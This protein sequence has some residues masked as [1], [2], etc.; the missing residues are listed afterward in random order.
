ML[1]VVLDGGGPFVDV[2]VFDDGE[3]DA[4]SELR[5]DADVDPQVGEEVVVVIAVRRRGGGVGGW[6]SLLIQSH[7]LVQ[8]L[9]NAG[10]GFLGLGGEGR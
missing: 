5:R 2:D 1:V 7:G 10:S 3:E 9:L 4:A 8:P 6:G